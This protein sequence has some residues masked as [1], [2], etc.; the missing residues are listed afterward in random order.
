MVED[1][2]KQWV[3]TSNQDGTVTGYHINH[4]DG[5]LNRAA[6]R[7][8]LPG[9]GQAGLPDWSAA[10]PAKKDCRGSAVYPGAAVCTKFEETHR[11]KWNSIC[12]IG[13]ASVLSLAACLGFTACS[14]DYTRRL[15]L[16]DLVARHHCKR[17][18]A[19]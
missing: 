18:T 13:A 17:R 6:T 1:P 15:S 14:R 3:Y 5:T 19:S 2:S 11:M 7:F 12:R 4:A 9:A 8:H 16:R 10:S